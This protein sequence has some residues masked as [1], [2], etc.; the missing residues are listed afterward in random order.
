MSRVTSTC[1]DVIVIGAGPAGM[2]A[3]LTAQTLGLRTLLLDEQPRAGGQIYRN[4]S[5]VQPAVGKLLG[6]DYL[7]GGALARKLQEQLRI[8]L[9]RQQR[10]QAD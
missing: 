8:S 4:V 10:L 9:E 7:H 2:A 1:F 3:A 6:P 5:E